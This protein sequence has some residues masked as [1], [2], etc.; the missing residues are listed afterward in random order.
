MNHVSH[1][2]VKSRNVLWTVPV[3]RSRHKSFTRTHLRHKTH[4]G[5][6]WLVG[7]WNQQVSFAKEPYKRDYVLQKRPIISRSLLIVAT[8]H[9]H[10]HTRTQTQAHKH[11]EKSHSVL[12]TVESV[13]WM[14]PRHPCHTHISHFPHTS[15]MSHI[16]HPCHTHIIHVT[17]TS[18]MSHTHQLCHTYII[19]V[20][21]TSSCHT[22]IIYVTHTSAMSHTLQLCHTYMG[23]VTH[24]SPM[25]HTHHPCH[26]YIIHV[27]HTS[28]MSHIHGA[29]NT[30][31]DVLPY[32]RIHADIY[33]RYVRHI[34][35]M[36][37]LWLVG[38]LK[39]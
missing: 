5:W 29:C 15:A 31:S 10:T 38:C 13:P 17:H 22:Y 3:P 26:T 11:A 25:S 19:N 23:H 35:H 20:T 33:I 16:H 7:S 39:I 27:T 2:W 9:T 30:Y 6:L 24:T 36:G 14:R 34:K 37:W 21:H 28:A 18:A 8:P 12:W 4:M 32:T 1:T